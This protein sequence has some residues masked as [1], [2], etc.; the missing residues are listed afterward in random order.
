MA[1]PVSLLF[2]FFPGLP[3]ASFGLLLL[4]FRILFIELPET[5]QYLA[6]RSVAFFIGTRNPSS[7][8]SLSLH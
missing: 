5:L 1:L 6:A 7:D 3:S 4:S 8:A 2:R